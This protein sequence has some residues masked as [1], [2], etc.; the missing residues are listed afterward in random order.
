MENHKI[1]HAFERGFDIDKEGNV[2]GIRGNKLKGCNERGYI[3][4]SMRI[5]DKRVNIFAHRLQAY[6]KFGDKIFEEGIVTRH[7]DGNP[8]NNSWDN[9]EIGTHSDNMMD[10]K[11]EVRSSKAMH[12]TS[13]VRKFDR[14]EVKK[15]YDEHKSYKKTMLHFNISSKGTLHFI[16]TK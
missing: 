4:F 7:L 2:I 8:I 11:P 3:Q 16:L 9:I 12:A 6:K 14:D 5:N 10:M 1:K 13:F 15:Y